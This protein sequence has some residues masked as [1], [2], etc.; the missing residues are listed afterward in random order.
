MST[1]PSTPTSRYWGVCMRVCV[2]VCVVCVYRVLCVCI[3]CCECVCVRLSGRVVL[4][5]FEIVRKPL[6]GDQVHLRLLRASGRRSISTVR[7]H[8]HIHSHTH[9][10]IH[11]HTHAPVRV[12]PSA[13]NLPHYSP[14]P[15]QFLWPGRGK[16]YNTK[17]IRNNK[18]PVYE[19]WSQDFY[20]TTRC[21][22]SVC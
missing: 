3:V 22:M 15:S 9:T 2:C 16:K 8:A 4:L 12:R 21:D 18:N 20:Y 13:V 7:T 6:S 19:D 5:T 10:D 17:M 11:I 1:R 14:T